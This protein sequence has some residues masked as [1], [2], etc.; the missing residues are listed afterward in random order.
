MILFGSQL[1]N[2][3]PSPH[4]AWDFVVVVRDYDP[5]HEALVAAG[6]HVRSPATLNRLARVLPPSITAFSPSPDGLPVA[7]CAIITTS[8]FVRALGP[9]SPDH[10]LKGRMVQKVRI[11]WARSES[12]RERLEGILADARRRVFEW[13][14]PWLSEPITAESLPEEMLRVSYAGEL[15][16][17]NS[18]RVLEV[19][20]SQR[21]WLTETYAQVLEAEADAGRLR[22]VDGGFAFEDPP[23]KADARRVRGYFRRSKRRAT[24]RWGKH[25]LTFN[26]W[27][28]YIQRKTERRTGLTIEITPAERRWP[29]LLLW[30]KVF[31]VLRARNRPLPEE[32]E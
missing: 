26:D 15:R 24:L 17:E 10:F 19:V 8:D 22:R 30:P 23:T 4:S 11:E 1:S 28:T 31:R 3:S 14:G 18:E 16:P 29:L 27:L 12:V 21:A 7:K 32:T 5:F 25:M 9:D 6:H 20:A 13:A 2:A